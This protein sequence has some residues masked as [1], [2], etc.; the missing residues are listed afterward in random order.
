MA[1]GSKAVL[2]MANLYTH[3]D[4]TGRV[5]SPGWALVTGKKDAT[6]TGTLEKILKITHDRHKSGQA[7]GLIE[8]IETAIELDMIQIEKLWGYLGLPV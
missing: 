7:P 2:A 4:L 6:I 5:K 1:G 8:E 3:D